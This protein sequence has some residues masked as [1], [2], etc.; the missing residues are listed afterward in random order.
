MCADQFALG[1]DLSE[2]QRCGVDYL[3]L[4][5]MDGVFVDNITL[6]IDLCNAIRERYDVPVDIHL[7]VKQPALLIERLCFGVGDI[8]GVHAESEADLAAIAASVHERGASFAVI[9]NPRTAIDSVASVLDNVDMV[10]LMMV[11]PGFAGLNLDPAILGKIEDTRRYLDDRGFEDMRLEVDG[12]VSFE[13]APRMR[14]RGADTFVAG[15]SSLFATGISLE[16]ALLR[17]RGS[18]RKK[19]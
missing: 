18:I 13:Y 2:L 1:R 11:E 17:L 15:S 14:E 5:I 8:V 6:G 12:N 16:A 19:A 10:S 4:D 9:L 3:H 7:L